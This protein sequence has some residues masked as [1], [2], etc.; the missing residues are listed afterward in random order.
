MS[1]ASEQVARWEY[2]RTC[3]TSHSPGC[4]R[5][6]RA[7][8][9]PKRPI[10]FDITHGRVWWSVLVSS[11]LP[12][13]SSLSTYTNYEAPVT[14]DTGV[15]ESTCCQVTSTKSG[16]H[17]WWSRWVN[18]TITTTIIPLPCVNGDSFSLPN[19]TTRKCR[20]HPVI[21]SA[22]SISHLAEDVGFMWWTCRS[23][24]RSQLLPPIPYIIFYLLGRRP[25]HSKNDRIQ[26]G[27]E[28]IQTGQWSQ[29]L[30]VI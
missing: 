2:E 27:I 9:N 23:T 25:C 19:A 30:F 20:D 16:F 15:H 7:R 3:R 18:I 22:A 13:G 12:S 29:W 4:S 1:S 21:C 26:L 17:F 24:G 8:S 14:S 10:S 5:P 28:E 6:I 11:Q